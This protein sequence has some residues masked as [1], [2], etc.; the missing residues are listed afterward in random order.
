MASLTIDYHA[1][2]G[3]LTVAAGTEVHLDREFLSGGT[4]V[5]LS[6][7][8]LAPVLR[9]LDGDWWLFNCDDKETILAVFVGHDGLRFPV[10]QRCA[11]PLP[12]G[13]SE[14]QAWYP[15]YRLAVSLTGV[16]RKPFPSPPV[17]APTVDGALVD[18]NERVRELFRRNSRAKAVMAAYCREYFSPGITRPDPT[19]R[20]LIKKCL[21]LESFVAVEKAL[22]AVSE[23]IWGAAS[24]HRHEIATYLVRHQL[25]V[26]A[27]QNLVP[28]HDCGHPRWTH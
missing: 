28:H 13:E 7:A 25:L 11:F 1:F 19:S 14:I 12:E 5:R 17:G 23:A 4:D 18:A 22:N 26:L 27:D 2:P 21:A 16:A 15:E 3:P 6:R 8:P 9:Q 20:P 24:G 10:G